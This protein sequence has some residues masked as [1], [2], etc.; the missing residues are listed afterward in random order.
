MRHRPPNA[1]R[2]RGDMPVPSARGLAAPMRRAWR[3]VVSPVSGR[4][5]FAVLVSVLLSASAGAQRGDAEHIEV[6]QVRPNIFVL[7]GGGSN[8]TVQ[9]G[10]DGVLLVDTKSPEVSDELLRAL[11]SVTAAPIRYIVNTSA[12]PEHIGGNE[13]L[14]RMGETIT[15]GNVAG[16]LA[17]AAT[18]AAVIAHENVLNRMV[19]DETAADA[20][21]TLTF[22]G[23]Q[24]DLFVNGEAINLFH[25][26]A[27]NTDGEIAVFFRRSDVLALGELYSTFGYPYID[28]DGGGSINGVIDALTF[29]VGLTVPE[30][31]QEG[32]TIVVPGRGRLS[33]EAD[34]VEYR[35]ML[36]IIRDRVR[37]MIEKGMALE[38]VLAAR[39]TFDYDPRYG[40]EEGDWPTNKFVEAVYSSL[41]GRIDRGER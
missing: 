34:L 28:V 25:H 10:L 26:P 14:A 29:A 35:D 38:D 21:P 32:G 8:T 20:W 41:S 31:R 27:A 39:P 1:D 36:V 30:V 40:S 19:A 23:A 17:D 37:D 12:L 16:L 6:V 5:S 9:I 24:Y 13:L 7:A 33:D 2:T 3:R 11:G 4:S 22:F 15:G 18:G